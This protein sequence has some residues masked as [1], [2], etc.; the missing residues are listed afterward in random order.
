MIMVFREFGSPL[1]TVV[2]S[3]CIPRPVSV[4]SPRVGSIASVGA[5]SLW[6]GILAVVCV[7]SF[8]YTYPG[9]Y[10]S[11]WALRGP[12]DAQDTRE[13]IDAQDTREVIMM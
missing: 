2:G 6:V 10:P 4:V 8:R 3:F 11:L 9:S 7:D 1:R 5:R 12:I 13:V